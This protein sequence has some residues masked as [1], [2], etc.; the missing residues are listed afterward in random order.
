[1]SD[2]VAKQNAPYQIAP[3]T[4]RVLLR[5]FLDTIPNF[6]YYKDRESRFV[7]VSKTKAARHGLQPSEL[8]GK[9]DA[10]FFSE[11]HTQW[12][13]VDEESIMETAEPLI[14]KLER[15]S[16]RDGRAGWGRVS[17]MPLRNPE[18]EI[19]GTF[20]I[21]YD[22]TQEQTIAL[23]LEKARRTLLDT[24]RQAGMAE[25]ATGVLHNVGNVLTS[26]NVS[27]DVLGKGLRHSKFET[28]NKL[29]A[30]MHEHVDDLGN[31]IVN[32]PKGRRVPEFLDSLSKHMLEERDRLTRELASLQQ[33]IDHIKEIITMQQ[34]YATMAGVVEP[35]DSGALVEDALR[36]N[37][38]ALVRHSVSVVREFHPVPRVRGEKAKV[39][40]ILVNLI[41]NAK[42]ACDDG[43]AADKIMTLRI[44]PG[45]PGRV[46]II[47]QDNGIGIAPENMDR[48]FQHGFT[49]RSAG[50]GFGLHSARQA[51]ADMQGT[52]TAE[53][54]GP[55]KGATFTLNLPVINEETGE[56]AEPAKA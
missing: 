51:A 37:A 35:L 20:G 2:G 6:V 23:E 39:L 52:L 38:G 44:K 32:D 42:Y 47:V 31:F 8:V 12:A 5:A 16:W 45:D 36:M 43:G 25:I 3:E 9:S 30:L 26:L 28:L 55:G 13:R 48:L 33:N 41:R 46:L 21:T 50:H 34:A 17:K 27:A 1:M 15:T 49:T 14:G 40:Q 53:S 11:E 29:A 19:V 56:A 54:K 22:V 7:A 24:S 4:A 18:G 10:D